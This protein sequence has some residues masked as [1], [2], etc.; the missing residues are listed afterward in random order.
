MLWAC[1][2]FAL[3]KHISGNKPIAAAKISN[4]LDL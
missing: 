1:Q 4:T 2:F 3:A